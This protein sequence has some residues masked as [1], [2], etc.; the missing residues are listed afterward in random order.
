MPSPIS[1]EQV[2]QV[3][4]LA[5]LGLTDTDAHQAA[6]DLGNILSHFSEIQSIDTQ[7]VPT[8]DDV[9]GL[10]NITRP[11][12]SEPEILCSHQDL[13]DTAPETMDA[14]I[15]VKAIFD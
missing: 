5:R 15:K 13:L 7:G 8:S 10:K 3:A 14:Q 6:Q 12:A 11:D 4:Q 9:T 2:K 1:L